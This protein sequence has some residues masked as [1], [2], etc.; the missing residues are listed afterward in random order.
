M[1][2][3]IQK[4]LISLLIMVGVFAVPSKAATY[5]I[6]V[7]NFQFSPDTGNFLVGDTLKWVWMSGNHTS[8]SNGVPVGAEVWNVLID[9]FHT[10]FTYIIKAAGTY[11]Y[12]SVPDLPGM[13]GEFTATWPV[14]ISSPPDLSNLI[15][16][17]TII[18]NYITV[19]FE[20]LA[21]GP[22]D[23]ALYNLAGERKQILFLGDLSPGEFSRTF[24]LDKKFAA[25]MY[26]INIRESSSILSRK[27]IV[28]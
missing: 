26:I 28:R 15:I 18:D 5:I 12:I 16:T 2:K 3:R 20:A 7:S 10:N 21:S 24:Y 14:G 6:E 9:S 4:A 27:I 17:P 11:H 1:K 25:G 23:I 13:T 22:V 8:T 19:E